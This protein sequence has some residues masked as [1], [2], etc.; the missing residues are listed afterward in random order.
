MGWEPEVSDLHEL[1]SSYILFFILGAG[2][3]ALQPVTNCWGW[4]P[5]QFP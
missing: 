4:I 1:S 5:E 3:A 2:V